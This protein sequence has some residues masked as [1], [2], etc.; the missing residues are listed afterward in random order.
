[1]TSSQTATALFSGALAKLRFHS[2]ALT[3]AQIRANYVEE[4]GGFPTYPVV[5]VTALESAGDVVLDL[6]AAGLSAGA[7]SAW[8]G[9]S[10]Q[11]LTQATSGNKPTVGTVGGVKAVTFDGGDWLEVSS[12]DSRLTGSATPFTIEAYIYNPGI[13][14]EESYFCWAPRGN[15]GATWD[16]K[17]RSIAY[18]SN[19]GY[20]AV[21]CWKS[22]WELGFAPLPAAVA[23]HHIVTTYDGATMRVY[24]DGFLNNA[25]AMTLNETTGLVYSIGR[26]SSQDGL[27]IKYFSGSIARL[28][29]CTGTLTTVQIFRNYFYFNHL[30]AGN[31]TVP[32]MAAYGGSGNFSSLTDLSGSGDYS[33]AD[34]HLGGGAA[35]ALSASA[36]LARLGLTDG[37]S[38]SVGSGTTLT[39]SDRVL[40]G[41]G[42]TNPV[43][44]T[45][46]VSGALKPTAVSSRYAVAVGLNGAGEMTIAQG[47]AVTLGNASEFWV[48]N[49]TNAYGKLTV[50][51]ALTNNAWFIVGRNGG[52]GDVT[53]DGGKVSCNGS[54][55]LGE[56]ANSA[57]LTMKNGAL[58]ALSTF[59][60]GRY[61]GSGSVEA[62]GGS[63]LTVTAALLND[64]S[65]SGV[66]DWASASVRMTD[67]T[68]AVGS[69]GLSTKN[70]Y[71]NDGLKDNWMAP[72]LPVEV[73]LSNSTLLATAN[74]RVTVP[75]GVLG[76][77]TLATAGKTI[78]LRDSVYGDSLA[79]SGGGL[80]EL[81]P[82][83]ALDG[84]VTVNG[85]SLTVEAPPYRWCADNLTV[86]HGSAVSSWAE[87]NYEVGATRLNTSTGPLMVTNAINGHQ[88]LRFNTDALRQ[89]RINPR[90]NPLAG[91]ESATIAVVFKPYANGFNSGL[92]A[93]WNSSLF[94][95]GEDSGSA[96]DWGFVFSQDGRI[97]LALSQVSEGGAMDLMQYHAVAAALNAP[98]VAL[99]A[100]QPGRIAL[101]LDGD[102][103]LNATVFQAKGG[104][105]SNGGSPGTLEGV[106]LPRA[107]YPIY[108][109]DG[110]GNQSHCFNGEIAEIRI[111]RNQCM[112][113]YARQKLVRD[114]A[115]GY[116]LTTI[117]ATAAAAMTNKTYAA[118]LASQ[119]V[120]TNAT[121]PAAVAVWS[122]DTLAQA[123]GATVSTWPDTVSARVASGSAVYAAVGVGG[124]PALQFSGSPMIVASGSNPVVGSQQFTAAIVFQADD[125]VTSLTKD[126]WTGGGLLGNKV[127][128][129]VNNDD[130][131]LALVNGRIVAGAGAQVTKT[132][133]Y[134]ANYTV[135]MV[136]KSK[137]RLADSKP[138]VVIYRWAN[139][140]A[141]AVSVDGIAVNLDSVGYARA[142]QPLLIGGTMS[143]NGFSGLIAEVRFY[144]TRLTDAQEAVVGQELA[145]KYGGYP[146][147]YGKPKALP[148]RTLK[149]VSA[150]LN[151]STNYCDP[152][153]SALQSNQTMVV[154]GAST[155]KGVL[156]VGNRAAL[157]LPSATDSLTVGDLAF[158]SGSTLKWLHAG[159]SSL[160]IHVAGDLGLPSLFTLDL[161]GRS[162]IPATLVT[163][164]EYGGNVTVPTG[165][166]TVDVIGAYKPGTKVVLIPAEKRVVLMTPSGTM[167]LVR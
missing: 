13:D 127:S 148:G 62:T 149:L 18:G 142:S 21:G 48:G 101:N 43:A 49:G 68:L 74:T 92:S 36:T 161:T 90:L 167:I 107:T 96:S 41:G 152:A 136:A 42:S 140:G 121:V 28:R 50:R 99:C 150:T 51:G 16:G 84:T 32:I 91:A 123:D 63:M 114:L 3:P 122:A 135:S 45:L 8:A 141:H 66:S 115:T 24:V 147:A 12:V 60:A 23:W 20:G 112:D 130:W 89:L 134:T 100:W 80:V 40:V 131:G 78:S 38:L 55:E 19:A 2:G 108:M 64:I 86:A 33:M 145:A 57:T 164:I 82:K 6:D 129:T 69:G 73:T 37:A 47:A 76:T 137:P 79:A 35:M 132:Y 39:A 56:Q 119:N 109:G 120:C 110:Q 77:N 151:I 156:C 102:E 30:L 103:T 165:G 159:H 154:T 160:P 52:V 111:Y 61:G 17:C 65:I 125:S 116:G 124:K 46:T 53:V 10:T 118:D 11:T 75:L 29:V 157:V 143:A 139:S 166:F 95:G 98:H 15:S 83:G 146:S 31:G 126:W 87:D 163:L 54:F 158:Q 59:L 5:A 104:S 25:K 9:N 7:L 44:S 94:I 153:L 138:H 34:V 117:A 88:T 106:T 113:R 144:G 162:G 4:R 71:Y 70:T 67:S 133:N 128:A 105:E 1:M 27:S 97:G 93:W 85:G 26:A 155:V 81:T 22:A 72:Y 58:C 14:N